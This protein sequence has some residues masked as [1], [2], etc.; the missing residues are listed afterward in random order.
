MVN[1]NES[2][3]RALINQPELLLLPDKNKQQRV[4]QR[5][6]FH[7]FPDPLNTEEFLHY[8]PIPQ[9]KTGPRFGPF[10]CIAPPFFLA[11]GVV[12]SWPFSKRPI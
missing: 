10:V 1:V 9:N 7:L 8:L 11:P 6:G 12:C 5:K 2:A 3:I 4:V